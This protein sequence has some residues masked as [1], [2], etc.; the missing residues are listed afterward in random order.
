MRSI[1]CFRRVVI[2]LLFTCAGSPALAQTPPPSPL[3]FEPVP[4]HF[5]VAPDFTV[6]DFDGDLGQLAGAYVGRVFDERL[7]VGGAGYW[8][9]NGSDSVK[10][11]YG[12]VVIGW[13]TADSGRIR[14]G[15][16]G[17]TGVGTA[18]LP[19]DIVAR[20]PLLRAR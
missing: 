7:L 6:T 18:T 5:V 20:V 8:L 11:M 12:G 16:R 4:S 19:F 15:A 17:L 3:V 13:S 14:F 10:L 2:A 1:H 9:A